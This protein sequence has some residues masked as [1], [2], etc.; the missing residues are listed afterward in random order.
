M[1]LPAE[2]LAGLVAATVHRLHVG[3]LGPFDQSLP[4]TAAGDVIIVPTP[5]HTV[6]HV[7]VIVRL[8]EVTYFLTATRPTLRP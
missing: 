3:P 4:L 1:G 7:S 2:S 5:G 6:G 8:A